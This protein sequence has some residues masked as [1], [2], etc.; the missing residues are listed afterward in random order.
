MTASTDQ[1][2]PTQVEIG[3]VDATSFFCL[4][5]R[6]TSPGYLAK[7]AWL[8]DRFAEGLRIHM[9]GRRERSR[10]TGDRGL[11]EY[12]PGKYAWRGIEAEDYLVIHCLWVVGQSRGKGGAQ[13]L[14]DICLEEAKAEGFAGVVAVAAENGFMTG[15]GFYEH[16]G[17]SAV[18][19]SEPRMSVMVYQM[20][21]D[22]ASPTLSA[23][24]KRGPAA[25]PTGLTI[26]RSD[27][28]PY[29]EDATATIVKEAEAHGITPIEV[30]ELDSPQTLREKSPTPYGVFGSVLDG[31]L[32]SY[33]YLT[34]KEFAT[35]VKRV[36][37]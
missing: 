13:Q 3:N 25:Y 9:L 2:E 34:P 15:R 32:L 29:I 30:V 5:S 19:E 12:I 8:E 17:F 22:A 1:V 14:L 26:F 4:Q 33:R 27:Q 20:D 16:A 35:A 18:A 10:W 28:C 7:R 37:G 31:Q 11:I 36:R 23:G 24:A 6:P 21:E